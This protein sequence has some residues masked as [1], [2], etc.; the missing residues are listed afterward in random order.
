[1]AETEK[2]T[3]ATA[4]RKLWNRRRRQRRLQAPQQ[5]EVEEEVGEEEEEEDHQ[6]QE[7]R[8]F[9]LPRL[10]F[11]SLHQKEKKNVSKRHVK[12]S[13]R[14]QK[15][16]SPGVGQ[17]ERS[18]S[19]PSAVAQATGYGGSSLRQRTEPPFEPQQWRRREGQLRPRPHLAR[20]LLQPVVAWLLTR[21]AADWS[22]L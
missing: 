6:Q 16:R 2:K 10:G 19:N 15:S 3:T 11:S 13:S 22:N 17:E 9:V 1:M 14:R 7:Q 8:R 21:L 20:Q 12:R 5:Q 4:K 18:V